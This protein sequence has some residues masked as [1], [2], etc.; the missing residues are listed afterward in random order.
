MTEQPSDQA[1]GHLL[2]DTVRKS[3]AWGP[4]FFGEK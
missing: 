3:S 4:K 2:F 1:E